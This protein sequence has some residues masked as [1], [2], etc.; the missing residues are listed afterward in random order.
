[1][2]GGW[3]QSGGLQVA[4]KWRAVG[5]PRGCLYAGRQGRAGWLGLDRTISA[6]CVPMIG[7]S[8]SGRTG[9]GVSDVDYRWIAKGRESFAGLEG[10]GA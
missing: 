2:Q 9:A 1:M 5:V 7:A 10:G 6:G 4:A 3:W 8:W